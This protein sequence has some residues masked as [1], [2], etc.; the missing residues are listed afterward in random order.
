MVGLID[1]SNPK[2]NYGNKGYT[3]IINQTIDIAINHLNKFGNLDL[4]VMDQQILE[5]FDVLNL[6]KTPD[7]NASDDFLKDFLN[8]KTRHN[9]FNAHTIAD[10]DDLNLRH[11]VFNKLLKPKKEL[12]CEI[13]EL[14]TTLNI[15]EKTLGVQIRGTDKK[16]EIPKIPDSVI[17]NSIERTLKDFNLNNIFLS[18]DDVNYLN[19]IKTNF[20]GIVNYNENNIIS[21]DGK[22]IH[23]SNNRQK[24]NKDVLLDVYLLSNCHYFSYCFSN[25][26]YLA[27]TL[28]IE[29]LKKIKYIDDEN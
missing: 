6:Y 4:L 14:K 25:V 11:E 20:K 21:H 17:I 13:D 19:L 28:G 12:V 27:L 7:Y 8:G 2:F 9:I 1:F 3:A 22:P 29:K 23:F 18:T 26:S 15:T 24:T 10:I 16:T 5:N